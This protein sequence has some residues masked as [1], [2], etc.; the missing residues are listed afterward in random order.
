M[1]EYA[2]GNIYVRQ[3]HLEH[4]GDEMPGHKHHFPHATFIGIGG[5]SIE[6]THDDGRSDKIE[7]WAG[8]PPVLILAECKHLITALTD[9]VFCCCIYSHRVPLADGDSTVVSD[10]TGWT[11]AYR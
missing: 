4:K 1:T 3:F 9:N 11:D 5:V 2:L 6:R 10:F 8:Q 7:M